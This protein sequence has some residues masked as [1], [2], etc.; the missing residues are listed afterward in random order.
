MT[1]NDNAEYAFYMEWIMRLFRMVSYGFAA[2]LLLAVNTYPINGFWMIAFAIGL[3]GAGS[4]S[5]KISQASL[6]LLLLMALLPYP[7]LLSFLPP[8]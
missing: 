5:A 2:V 6:A 4:A 7:L 8:S 3:L 1:P